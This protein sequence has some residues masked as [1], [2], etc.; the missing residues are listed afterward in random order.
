MPN[1]VHMD[2]HRIYDLTVFTC[3]NVFSI[4]GPALP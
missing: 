2:A 1:G 4:W 3:S